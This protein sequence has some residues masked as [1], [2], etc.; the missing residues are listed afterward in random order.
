ME[1][2]QIAL[3]FSL[4]LSAFLPLLATLPDLHRAAYMAAAASLPICIYT[5]GYPIFY[6][7]PLIFPFLF[8][9][10]GKLLRTRRT[11]ALW[12]LFS[13]HLITAILLVIGVAMW[14]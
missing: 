2:I 14:S 5:A 12:L 7:V 13:P 10:G 3:L 11:I 1:L 8:I 4:I 6:Y 9:A